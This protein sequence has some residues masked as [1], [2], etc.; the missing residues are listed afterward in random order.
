VISH[1]TILILVTLFNFSCDSHM[2]DHKTFLFLVILRGRLP[3]ILFYY[4]CYWLIKGA[5]ASRWVTDLGQYTIFHI[6]AQ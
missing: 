6:V 2:T 5:Y 1:K 4:E 3:M